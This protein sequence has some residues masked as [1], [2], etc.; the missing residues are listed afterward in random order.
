MASVSGD[1][2]HSDDRAP[3]GALGLG[4]RD[5]DDWPD[6]TADREPPSEEDLH[7][8]VFDPDTSP[9]DGWEPMTEAQRQELLGSDGLDD[10]DGEPAAEA[11]EAGFTH[12]LPS[13][14]ATGFAAGGPLR[15]LIQPMI[16]PS[17][18]RHG[19]QPSSPARASMP[20]SV[21]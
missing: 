9:P 13:P 20:A 6:W 16:V 5:G 1:R 18:A 4:Y 3:A 8:L 2:P 19:R 11:L 17:G 21:L 14:G 12:H 7:G 15:A 10:Y